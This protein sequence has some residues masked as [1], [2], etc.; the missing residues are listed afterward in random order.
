MGTI[1][2]TERAAEEVKRIVA[3]GKADDPNAPETM[4]LRLRIVG[5]G[6]S[7]FQ[8]KLDLEPTINEK[9]DEV[10]EAHGVKLVVDKR[11]LLY[12]EGST[13]DFHE[14]L[15]KRGFSVVNPQATGRC[16]CGSSFSM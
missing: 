15:N 6:C 7:G 16:G 11:S 10:I 13:I 9:L 5:G 2:L 3:E 14:D 8:N 1:T 12:A 4:Y